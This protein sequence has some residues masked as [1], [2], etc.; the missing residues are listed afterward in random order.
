M[1]TDGTVGCGQGRGPGGGEGEPPGESCMNDVTRA[2]P[3]VP[4]PNGHRICKR[5]GGDVTPPP[6]L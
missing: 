1:T 2:G 5:G 3:G 4:A 6:T